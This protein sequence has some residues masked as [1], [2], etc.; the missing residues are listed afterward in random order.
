MIDEVRIVIADDHPVV[1]GGLKQTI[2]SDSKLR[3][4]GEAGD[5]EKALAC[6]QRLEPHI[7]VVDLEMPKLDGLG[8][9]RQVKARNLPVDVIILTLHGE[10]DLFHEAMD[11]GAKGYILKESALLE[12]GNGIR[13][14]AAGQYYVTTSLT[15]HLLRRRTRAQGL[16]QARP[17]LET[18]TSTERY[19]VRAVANSMSSKDIAGE[20]NIH[21]RTVENHRTMIC[22]KLQLHG[23]HALLK[24]ALHHKAEL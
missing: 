6:I 1:L 8:V 22:Q 9:I 4:V 3:V 20:M 24:F 7:A 19:I 18:L 21:Y 14:V 15:A 16:L 2:E 10:E 23:P 11:S 17:S 12:I 13:A 5:G